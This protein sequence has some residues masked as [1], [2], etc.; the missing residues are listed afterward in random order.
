M[1]HYNRHNNSNNVFFYIFFYSLSLSVV[2]VPEDIRHK[3]LQSLENSLGV[4]WTRYNDSI[5]SLFKRQRDTTQ[6][7][8][9][10]TCIY[11][12]NRQRKL[13]A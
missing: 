10:R 3:T 2:S 4:S 8:I 13:L 12:Y 6:L 9:Q 11:K 5:K 1:I 7:S